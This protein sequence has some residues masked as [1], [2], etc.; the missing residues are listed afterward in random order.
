[1]PDMSGNV[2][3]SQILP[4]RQAKKIHKRTPLV[5]CIR[6]GDTYS[7]GAGKVIVELLSQHADLWTEFV[8]GE[9]Q[10][11]DQLFAERSNADWQPVAERLA[12]SKHFVGLYE[13]LSRA[14]DLCLA[15]LESVDMSVV[16]RVLSKAGHFREHGGVALEVLLKRGVPATAEA[17]LAAVDCA[18]PSA[19]EQLLE[20]ADQGALAALFAAAW[21]VQLKEATVRVSVRGLSVAKVMRTFALATTPQLEQWAKAGLNLIAPDSDTG[22]T[23]LEAALVVFAEHEAAHTEVVVQAREA[24][25]ALAK[26][27]DVT[28]NRRKEAMKAEEEVKKAD[29]ALSD[30]Q[31]VLSADREEIRNANSNSGPQTRSDEETMILTKIMT[32]SSGADKDLLIGALHTMDAVAQQGFLAKLATCASDANER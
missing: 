27:K 32:S 12:L 14:P 24:A 21:D 18:E 2:C 16:V 11:Q 8:G 13:L 1:M 9:P 31:R 26:E 5:F 30:A 20:H 22:E 23:P 4:R 10:I 15:F 17:L 3:G 7:S 19:C 25:A 28:E 6:N 29:T